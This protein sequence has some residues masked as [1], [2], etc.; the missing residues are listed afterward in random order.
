MDSRFFFTVFLTVL[1]ALTANVQ[2]QDNGRFYIDLQKFPLYVKAGFNSSDAVSPDLMDGSWLAK[3]QWPARGAVIRR[4]G[5]PGLPK[6]VFLSPWGRP[7]Q[8]WTFAVPFT[9]D[10][11]FMDA[12]ALVIPCLYLASI[13]INWEIYLNGTLIKK[14]MHLSGGRITEQHY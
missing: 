1:P 10:A 3:E 4:L 2:A 6:R 13:G 9:M 14:E 11:S 8:E 12:D 5:L 7:K